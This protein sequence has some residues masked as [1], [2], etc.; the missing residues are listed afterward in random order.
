MQLR[1]RRSPNDELRAALLSPRPQPRA[2]ALLS[3]RLGANEEGCRL[4]RRYLEVVVRSADLYEGVSDFVD[5]C[6]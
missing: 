4:A 6:D 3:R 5:R 1:N 2:L